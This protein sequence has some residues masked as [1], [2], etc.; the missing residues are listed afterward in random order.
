VELFK[1]Y[2]TLECT[3]PPDSR[4]VLETPTYRGCEGHQR[5]LAIWNELSD[6]LRLDPWHWPPIQHPDY[7]T[8]DRAAQQLWR[9]LA[10]AAE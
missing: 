1:E 8:P 5:M 4:G 7:P 6:E 9:A 3:C 2:L 10:A